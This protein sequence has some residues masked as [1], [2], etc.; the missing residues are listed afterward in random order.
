MRT[1]ASVLAASLFLVGLSSG[2]TDPNSPEFWIRKLKDIRERKEARRQLVKLDK[3]VA[4]PALMD[5]YKEEKDPE[6]LKAIVHFHDKRS[7][8]LLIS[9]LGDFSEETVDASSIAAVELGSLGDPAA[10]DP[11]IKVL[12]NK[13]IPIRSRANIV[14]QEAM[15]SLA[16]FPKDAKATDALVTVL[17]RSADEQDFFLN[18]F[19]A[20]QLGNIADPKAIPGLV[21]G[22]FMTGRGADIFQECRTS[23]AQMG[24]PAVDPLIEL[25]QEKNEAVNEMRKKLDFDKHTPGVIPAKAAYVL[26]DLRPKKALPILLGRLKERS[27]D[28]KNN[29]RISILV[30]LGQFGDPSSIPDIV[31]VLKDAGSSDMERGKAA[32]ALNFIG[33]RKVLPDLYAC[34]SSQK[35]PPNLRV[36]CGFAYASLGTDAEFS[37]FEALA[38]SEGYEEF[39]MA[40][41]RLKLAKECK[42]DAACYGKVFAGSATK[43]EVLHQMLKAGYELGRLERGAALKVILDNLGKTDQL[44]VEQALLFALSRQAGKDCKECKEKVNALLDKQ[45]KTPTKIAKVF[46]NELKVSAALLGR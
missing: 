19:A 27:K 1:L 40:L 15:R 23:L 12:E 24:E 34:V 22:L 13:K 25:L 42:Q 37:K 2:C 44:E 18:K 43:N 4:V 21:R 14:K 6:T 9:V 3:P 45:E 17:T 28:S 5:L 30:T 39:K 46:A 35:A 8:P 36:A 31:A 20:I 16:R 7:V 33:D 26:G 32:E 41:E 10:V 38:K 29:M 11:L